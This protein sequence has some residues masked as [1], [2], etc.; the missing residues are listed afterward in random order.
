MKYDIS[1]ILPFLNESNNIQCLTLELNGFISVHKKIKFEV[2]FVDD[3]SIDNSIELLQKSKLKFDAKIIKLSKNFGSHI[4]LRAGIKNALGKYITF[5]Y[6]DLQDPPSL[7]TEMYAK[8]ISGYDIV[9]AERKIDNL[10]F[11]PK[12]LSSLYALLM[13]K[14]VDKKFPSK[15]FDIV[16]FNDKIANE[17]N[18]NIESNSSIFLQILTMGFKQDSITYQKLKRKSGKSKWTLSKKIKVF[19]DSFVAF[20]YAPIRF[21][22]FI[23]FLFSISG[24]I[25]MIYIIIRKIIFENVASGWPALISILMIGFG[26][27]NISLG[28]IAEYLWRAL[29]VSRK[30]S[31][32]VIDKLYEIRK[33]IKK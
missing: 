6:A 27:T 11:I 28:I 2:I 29:D 20:S 14:F 13:R 15:G 31:V 30:R 26:I 18:R 19:I 21:V 10:N 33:Y 1:I 24:L 32:Y 8:C 25:F 4:A 12:I 9:W 17:L 23:G 22:S 7:I 3:G 5:L 16:M